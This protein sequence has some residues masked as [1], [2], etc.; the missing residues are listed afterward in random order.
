MPIHWKIDS[1]ARL[2]VVTAEGRVT[3]IE[4]EEYLEAVTGARANGYAKIFD[5]T[6]GENGMTMDDMLALAARFRAMH[7]EPHGALAVVLQP[8]RQT[9]LEPVIGALAAANRPLRLFATLRT[10]RNWIDRQAL[11][12]DTD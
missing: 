2:V 8:A 11:L 6:N 7:A 3:R 10:A 9:A 1:R 5:G 12:G 4:F